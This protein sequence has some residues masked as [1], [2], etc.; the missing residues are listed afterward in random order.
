[1]FCYTKQFPSLP[2]FGSH[3]KPHGVIGLRNNYHIQFDPKLVHGICPIRRI[4]CACAWCTYMLYKP[5]IRGLTPKQQPR[6]RYVTYWSY[7]P[8]LGSFNNWNIITFSHKSTTS[9]DFEEFHQVVLYS[10]SDN[11]ASLVQY[12]KYGGINTTDI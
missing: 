7:C 9:E 8:V 4:T 5:W 11:M 12:G 3:T 10:I 6:Y 1:M 2:F